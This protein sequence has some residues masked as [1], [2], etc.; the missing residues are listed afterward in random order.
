VYAYVPQSIASIGDM[1]LDAN[2]AT[3]ANYWNVEH[4]TFSLMQA[5]SWLTVDDG[6]VASGTPTA[7]GVFPVQLLV[8]TPQLS[9]AT[10]PQSFT[11]TVE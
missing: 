5:P 2:T 8:T 3:M 7:P 11:I 1:T 10:S 9:N 6:G 4:P